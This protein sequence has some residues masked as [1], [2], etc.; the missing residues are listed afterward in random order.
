MPINTAFL[1]NAIKSKTHRNDE[2][3]R[4]GSL[5]RPPFFRS[6]NALKLILIFCGFWV[7]F[8]GCFLGCFR[9]YF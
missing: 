6:S 7:I 1:K 8:W 4:G 5:Y 9:W 3:A 2:T